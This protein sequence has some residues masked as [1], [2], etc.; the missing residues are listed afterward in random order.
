MKVRPQILVA[1]LIM[2]L[3]AVAVIFAAPDHIPE[4]VG[5][6]VSGLVA[7]GTKLLENE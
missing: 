4:I 2:G 5:P 3:I 6:T 7:L 1:M